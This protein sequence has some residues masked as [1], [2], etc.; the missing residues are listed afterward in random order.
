MGSSSHFP[1]WAYSNDVNPVCCETRGLQPPLEKRKAKLEKRIIS[2]CLQAYR[3][4]PSPRHLRKHARSQ[5]PPSAGITR[6]R[7]AYDPVRLPPMPPPENDVE[8]A[9]RTKTGLPRRA[10]PIP[11]RTSGCSRRLLPRARGLGIRIVTFDGCSGFTHVTARG[12]AQPPLATSVTR[13]QLM[14]LPA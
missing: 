9:P 11:R 2:R 3:Q 10:A 7:P 5:G 14:R 8:A 1:L 6:L 12:I 4:S 13:L